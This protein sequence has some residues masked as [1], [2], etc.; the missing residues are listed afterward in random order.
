MRRRFINP[1]ILSRTDGEGSLTISARW[2]SGN[3]QRYF[4]SL[5]MTARE[6]AAANLKALAK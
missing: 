4:A 3:G 6:G 2:G 1:V 5:N